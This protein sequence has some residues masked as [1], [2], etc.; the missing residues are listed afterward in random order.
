MAKIAYFDCLSGISGDMTLGALID[1]GVESAEIQAAVRS[2]GLAELSITASEVKKCGFRAVSVQIDHPPEHAHRHLHHITEMIDR[3]DQIDPAAKELAHQ[4]FYQVAVAE[5]KVHGTTIEKVHFH[6]VGAIDSI[7]DIV[8]TAVAMHALGIQYTIASPIPTGT[9][10]ITIAHGRVS[11]PAPA[12]AEILCGVPI[13][14]CDIHAELTTP[15]GAAIIKATAKRF[16]SVPAMTIDAVGYGAGTMD[17]DGQANVLRVMLGD[18]DEDASAGSAQIESDRV[19]VVETNVDDSTP[20]QLADCAQRLLAEGAL[21]VFQV[22]CTMKKGRAA[23]LLSVIAPLDKVGILEQLIFQHS[24]SIGVRR[25]SVD[26]HKLQR[27]NETVQTEFGPVRAKLVTL[28][29]GHDRLTVEDD[30]AR[31]LATDNQTTT[32]EI[33]QAAANAWRK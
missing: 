25:Y 32:S 22:P 21:D 8:G 16:G 13:A 27:R 5:A 28:P 33:R 4:I 19:V 6:E 18:I 24:T 29:D 3:A 10:S 9:G 11:V 15:T 17:L 2:M 12:T 26:R 31:K 14:P 23:T 7:A 30:D 20:E 1:L